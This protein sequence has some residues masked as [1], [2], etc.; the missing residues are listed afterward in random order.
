VIWSWLHRLGGPGLILLGLADN[1]A[2][3]LPGSMDVFTVLLAA[4]NREWWPYYA[5]MATVGAVVGGYLTYRLAEKGGEET[6]EKK[7]GK[8]KAQKIYKKFEKQGEI[9]VF[10]GAILPPP[11]PIVPVLTA[12]GV[13]EF[14]KHK[15]LAALT[16]GRAIRFFTLAWIAH[17]Y[18][19][20]ILGW[21]SHYRQPLLY[22]L[23][24]MAMAGATGALV[25]FKWYRSRGRTAR[26]AH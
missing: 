7:I 19:V 15:F 2:I 5:F 11:F 26:H 20:A 22:V 6:L 14:P 17:I 4:H 16:L 18:G 21:L 12:A 9:W 25:Y 8:A 10:L 24:S 23:I 1:S 3:P 13:L